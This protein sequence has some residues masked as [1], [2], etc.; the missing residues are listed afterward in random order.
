MNQ[1]ITKN[2]VAGHLNTAIGVSETEFNKFIIEAQDLDIKKL[3]NEL[4]YNDLLKNHTEAKYVTLLQGG[5]YQYQDK[6]YSFTGFGKVIAYYAY[7]RFIR[8]GSFSST[9]HGHV[10]KTT[11]HSKPLTAEE[12][13]IEYKTYRKEASELF[14]DVKNFLDR[15]SSDYDLWD[16]TLPSRNKRNIKT[17]II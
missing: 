2:G 6:T 7:A 10:V 8:K 9:S 12:R 4:L 13:L 1:L 14:Q 3:L 5:E 16:C 15:K 17:T 11:P